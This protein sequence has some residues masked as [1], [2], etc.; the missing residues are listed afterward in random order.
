MISLNPAVEKDSWPEGRQ[1]QDDG[2][3]Q[4][5]GVE[6]SRF[7]TMGVKAIET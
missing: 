5:D 7:G 3:E 4:R 1:Q 2:I 6:N